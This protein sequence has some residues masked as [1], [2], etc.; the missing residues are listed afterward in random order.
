ML[1]IKSI[2]HELCV[3]LRKTDFYQKA[4]NILI[5]YPLKYEIDTLE[6][7]KEDKNFYLPRVSGDDINVCPY[8][9]ELTVSSLNI[10]EPC[11]N[12]V[13]AQV[14]DLIIVPALMIDGK[15]YRLGYGGGFYDRF[16]AKYPKIPTV[17]LIAKEL[18]VEELPH[19]KYDIPLN[20]VIKSDI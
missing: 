8:T 16:L 19:E 13:S 11:S 12:P 9:D 14:L 17:G 18:L 7:L 2:S 1:D 6:L 10:K 3:K 4:K 20:W 15:N 5:F